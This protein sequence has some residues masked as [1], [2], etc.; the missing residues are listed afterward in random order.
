[1]R[2]LFIIVISVVTFSSCQKEGYVYNHNYKFDK[3]E[4]AYSSGSFTTDHILTKEEEKQWC[5]EMDNKIVDIRNSYGGNFQLS[6]IDTS[7][8]YYICPLKDF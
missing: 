2:N 6:D 5:N 7:F 4:D 3:N 8:V 1:M